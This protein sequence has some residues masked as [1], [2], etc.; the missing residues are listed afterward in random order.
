MVYRGIFSAAA[1]GCSDYLRWVKD[2]SLKNGDLWFY[3]D[4]V[5]ILSLFQQVWAVVEDSGDKKPGRPYNVLRRAYDDF[6]AWIEKSSRSEVSIFLLFLCFSV[7]FNGS[8]TG[9]RSDGIQYEDT[10]VPPS[11]FLILRLQK[12]GQHEKARYDKTRYHMVIFI[13]KKNYVFVWLVGFHVHRDCIVGR[14][15]QRACKL[16]LGEVLHRCKW[17]RIIQFRC[18]MN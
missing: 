17:F 15:N 4:N 16:R 11:R 1:Y 10:A 5:E 14:R 8:L 9:A 7:V 13:G 2:L 6:E 3:D 12:L 18:G